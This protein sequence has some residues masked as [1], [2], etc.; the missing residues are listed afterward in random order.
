MKIY[1]YGNNIDTDVIIPA[2]Y[3]NITDP[4]HLASH[5]MEDLDAAFSS[6]VEVGDV[7]VAEE[8]FGCGSS[9]EHAVLAIKACGVQCV[10]AK[11]FARIFFRNALNTGLAI[12]E[13]PEAVDELA[14]D[15]EIEVDVKQGIIK[16][17]RDG[18]VF[19]FQAYPEFLLNMIENNGLVE[20]T[21][22]AFEGER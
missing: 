10:I 4:K 6:T 5:C 15:D 11:N 22:K 14:S 13:C 21:K 12:I 19:Q 8:N 1:K 9:R 18:K 20:T 2:R 17:V 3:L 7:I 16:R